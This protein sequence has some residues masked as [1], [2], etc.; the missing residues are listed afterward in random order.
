MNVVKVTYQAIRDMSTLDLECILQSYKIPVLQLPPRDLHKYI[1]VGSP[2]S[3]MGSSEF[4]FQW[5]DG[6]T[7]MMLVLWRNNGI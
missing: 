4:P 7:P 2:S 3:S 1:I 6:G 5:D